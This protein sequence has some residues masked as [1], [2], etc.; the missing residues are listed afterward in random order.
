MLRRRAHVGHLRSVVVLPAD[1]SS[2]DGILAA[3]ELDVGRLV[4]VVGRHGPL[5]GR[6]YT[7][8][9]LI[10]LHIALQPNGSGSAYDYSDIL[11][12]QSG[13]GVA[14]TSQPEVVGSL[15]PICGV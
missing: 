3:D 10:K 12:V 11:R 13:R 1:P 6:A 15:P 4:G 2:I 7:T 5:Q 9:V 14:A 8:L